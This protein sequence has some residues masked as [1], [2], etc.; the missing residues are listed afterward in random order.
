MT[1]RALYCQAN[2]VASTRSRMSVIAMDTMTN[3]IEPILT[4][5]TPTVSTL[6]RI[7]K[8]I[9][10]HRMIPL[11]SMKAAS[12]TGKM[13]RIA[14]LCYILTRR[15]HSDLTLI[16]IQTSH[17]PCLRLAQLRILRQ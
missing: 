5:K 8:A 1:G 6:T 13:K 15:I 11:H 3:T 10:T 9:L 4:T 14:R 7:K 12:I 17:T 16:N 2:M